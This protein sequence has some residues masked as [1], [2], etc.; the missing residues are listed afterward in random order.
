M[1]ME[2]RRR[3]RKAVT[4][5]RA[6]PARLM[7]LLVTAA[8]KRVTGSSSLFIVLLEWVQA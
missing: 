3:N 2:N 7:G 5:V 6:E 4:V 8:K 1:W